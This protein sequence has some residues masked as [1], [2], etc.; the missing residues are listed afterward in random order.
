M[1]RQTNRK[2]DYKCM[3]FISAKVCSKVW[4]KNNN[5]FNDEI[6]QTE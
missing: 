2:T 1:R 3:H 4:S 6:E 5:K